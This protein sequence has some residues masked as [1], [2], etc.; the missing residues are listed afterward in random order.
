[1][2]RLVPISSGK[3]YRIPLRAGYY[4]GRTLDRFDHDRK[5]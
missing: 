3:K 5:V 4:N 2:F 1:M